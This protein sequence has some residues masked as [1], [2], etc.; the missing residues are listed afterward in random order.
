MWRSRRTASCARQAGRFEGADQRRG[1]RIRRRAEAAVAVAAEARADRA[2]AGARHR[3][4]ARHAA[5][6]QHARIAAPLA[7]DAHAATWAD[8]AACRAAAAPARAAPARLF[9]RAALD[10]VVDVHV[11]GDRRRGGERRGS[12]P[13]ADRRSRFH[14][15]TSATLRSAWMP[16]LVAHA[17]I[18]TSSR[19]RSRMSRM[20]S[21]SCAVVMLPSTS[22][23]SH[24]PSC[25]RGSTPRGSWRSRR[26]RRARAAR[27]RDSGWRAGSRRRTRT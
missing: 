19:L 8:R 10:L 6:H 17:P 21:A 18:V 12:T 2:A 24:G 23:T 27:P 15:S 4:Q 5:R 16:P 20:R 26:A 13:G 7:L 3:P 14:A 25:R 22:V 9:D 1:I 11:L